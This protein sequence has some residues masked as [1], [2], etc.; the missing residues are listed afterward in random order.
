VR[1]ESLSLRALALLTYMGVAELLSWANWESINR[2]Q[3]TTQGIQF[4]GVTSFALSSA[5]DLVVGF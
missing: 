5:Q 4:G 3:F 2:T 1:D